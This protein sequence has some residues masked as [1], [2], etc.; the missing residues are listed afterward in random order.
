MSQYQ[1]SI[2]LVTFSQFYH[3]FVPWSV[4][5][6]TL[7][8]TFQVFNYLFVADLQSVYLLFFFL[9]SDHNIEALELCSVSVYRSS[10]KLANFFSIHLFYNMKTKMELI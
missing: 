9:L 5:F 4:Y 2:N 3:L 1:F 7:I 8:F 10:S 6:F